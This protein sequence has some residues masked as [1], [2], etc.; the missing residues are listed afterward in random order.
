MAGAGFV[1]LRQDCLP[2]EVNIGLRPERHLSRRLRNTLPSF[3]RGL[4][5]AVTGNVLSNVNRR[6]YRA[7]GPAG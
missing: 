1:P 7:T 5:Y 2:L 6:C 3:G 4:R